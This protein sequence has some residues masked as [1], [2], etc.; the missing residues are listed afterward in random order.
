MSLTGNSWGARAIRTGVGQHEAL[1]KS[2]L[3]SMT[4]LLTQ[5]GYFEIQGRPLKAPAVA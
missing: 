4:L 5:S 3:L 2:F 1:T